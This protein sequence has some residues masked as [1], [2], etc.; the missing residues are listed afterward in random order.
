MSRPRT[1]ETAASPR[2]LSIWALRWAAGMR[3]ERGGKGE[4]FLHRH[5]LIEGRLLR[6]VADMALGLAG[7]AARSIPSTVTVPA[8]GTRQPV[9]R[10][11]VVVLPAPLGPRKPA[12][13][14]GR[15]GEADPLHPP[16]GGRNIW[17]GPPL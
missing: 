16:G 17:S 9:I 14:P 8:S 5:I 7:W 3:F 6:Q 10:F 12:A 4:I 11:M 1:P 13:L 15:E 2:A